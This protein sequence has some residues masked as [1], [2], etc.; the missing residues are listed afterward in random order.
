V[1]LL[2]RPRPR[3]GLLEWLAISAALSLGM[4]H[5]ITVTTTVPHAGAPVASIVLLLAMAAATV[6]LLWRGNAMTVRGGRG[7]IPWVWSRSRCWRSISIIVCGLAVGLIGSLALITAN[8]RELRFFM[9]AILAWT[10]TLLYL[11]RSGPLTLPRV[12]IAVLVVLAG[13]SALAL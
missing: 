4:M 8:Q 13:L 6:A 7:P 10:A 9:S 11:A 12:R 1:S 3:L 5:L 2:W